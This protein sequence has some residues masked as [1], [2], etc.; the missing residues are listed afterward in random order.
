VTPRISVTRNVVSS[1]D[2]AEPYHEKRHGLSWYVPVSPP[3][4]FLP[5]LAGLRG[6]TAGRLV[7][8]VLPAA[9]LLAGALGL[10]LASGPATSTLGWQWPGTLSLVV[11]GLLLMFGWLLQ[12]TS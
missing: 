8:L 3:S 5:L 11:L 9:W 2:T 10:L 4:P 6:A 1:G 12:G 7:L